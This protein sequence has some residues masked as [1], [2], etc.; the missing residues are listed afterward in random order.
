[1]RKIQ[2]AKSKRPRY[3][4]G[5]DKGKEKDRRVVSGSFLHG[6]GLKTVTLEM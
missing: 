5:L 4:D 1:M 6:D 2:R 3:G